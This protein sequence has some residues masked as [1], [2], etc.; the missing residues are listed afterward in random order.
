MSS[1][2]KRELKKLKKKERLQSI[3]KVKSKWK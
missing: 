3:E 2:V 1:L